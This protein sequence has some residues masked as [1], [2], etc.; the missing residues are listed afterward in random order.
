MKRFNE[1]DEEFICEHCNKKVNKS[2]K[3]ERET[4]VSLS[5]HRLRPHFR[6]LTK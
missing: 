6:D 4:E 1:L 2:I 3:N 5:P